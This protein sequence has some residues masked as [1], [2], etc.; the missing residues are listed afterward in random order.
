MLK[1][2]Y[3]ILLVRQYAR[4]L[5]ARGRWLSGIRALR[6]GFFPCPY[7]LVLIYIQSCTTSS[8]DVRIRGRHRSKRIQVH[9][10][11]WFAL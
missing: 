4:H 10:A 5:D 2:L 8:F 6:V 11:D 7:Y 1:L 3:A 9:F